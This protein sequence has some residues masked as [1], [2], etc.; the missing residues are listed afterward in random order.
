MNARVAAVVKTGLREFRRTPVLLAL[1]AVLPAYFVGVFVLLVPDTTVPLAI[2]GSRV[3][4]SM[5]AFAAVLMTGVAVAIVCGIVGLF[6]VLASE[7]ADDRLRLAGCGGLELVLS[8]ITTLSATVAVVTVVS[9]GVALQVFTPTNTTG[10]VLLAG[11]M[12]ITYGVVGVVVGLLVDKLAGVYVMLFVP[13]IDVLL[14]QNPL[15]T[16]QPEWATYLPGHYATKALFD[17][18]FTP[19]I[20]AGTALGS[21]GYATVLLTV[22]MVVFYRATAVSS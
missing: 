20:D 8:R 10:F 21:V 14:F 11:I 5:T 9:A 4:I 12:G 13:M 1:L 18:G 3:S 15:A 17:A 7:R 22:C 16:Q 2:A 19:E 6:L